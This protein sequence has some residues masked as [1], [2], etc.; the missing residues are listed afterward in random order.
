M[1]VRT[2][3]MIFEA[4]TMQVFRVCCLLNCLAAAALLGRAAFAENDAAGAGPSG[5]PAPL[6]L[7]LPG[8]LGI[9]LPG[10]GPGEDGDVALS[11]SYKIVRGT[12]L[13]KVIVQAEITPGR[14][15]FSLTMPTGGSGL[16]S[17]LVVK[18]EDV[19]NLGTL[20]FKPN[21][22][23][24]SVKDPFSSV[25]LEEYEGEVTWT[26]DLVFK[27]RTS[28]DIAQ[29][30]VSYDGQVCATTC[31]RINNRKLRAKCAGYIEPSSTPGEFRP[32]G[33]N[34]LWKG[35]LEPKVVTPGSQ[36]RLV[37]EAIP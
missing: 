8:E 7:N 34:L 12:S 3:P 10:L 35:R 1:R 19:A 27:E 18:S 22:P 37:F 21:R 4:R 24:S 16:P 13:G 5:K 26:A 2:F 23:P 32:K 14:H 6:K 36:A 31:I 11:A 15:T 9:G 29:I 33:N 20:E 17:K 25:L 28:A 30:A